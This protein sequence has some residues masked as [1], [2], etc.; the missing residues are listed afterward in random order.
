[1]DLV[2]TIGG[3]GSNS[4]ITLDDAELYFETRLHKAEWTAATDDD[5]EIALMWATR[6]LDASIEW[7][8]TVVDTDQALQWPRADVYDRNDTLIAETVIPSDILNATCELALALIRSERTADL[9]QDSQ[10][11]RR[12]KAG[13]VELEFKDLVQ[14]KVIPD[15]VYAYV[16]PYGVIHSPKSGVATLLRS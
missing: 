9:D 11:L 14:A 2:A 8:G 10:G 4:Y 7:K 3:E 12:L 6:L 15:A 13:P 5:K 1:M 16:R